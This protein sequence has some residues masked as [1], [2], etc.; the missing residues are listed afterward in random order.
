MPTEY[1]PSTCWEQLEKVS[2]NLGS[3]K[4]DVAFNDP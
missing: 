2:K 1:N 4:T 3:M